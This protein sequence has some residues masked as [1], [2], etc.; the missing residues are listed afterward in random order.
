MKKIPIIFDCDTGTDDAIAI[1]S[2]L[3]SKEL[4]IRAFTTV[5]GNVHLR[6]T[7]RNT[8]N[9]VDYLGFKIKVAAGADKPLCRELKVAQCHGED[10]LGGIYL[11][12]AK[13]ELYEKDAIETIYEEALKLRGELEIVAVGPLT[14]IAQ[15]LLKHPDLKKLIKHITIMGGAMRGGNMTQVAEFNIFVDP[16]AAKIV[17]EAGIP[18]TM[19]GLDVT[20][21][22][23]IS[24]EEMQA[25]KTIDTKAGKLTYEI[26]NYMVERS[27][28]DNLEEAV[29]HDGLALGVCIH[30][31][32]VNTES[33]YVNVETKGEFTY[34]HTFCD[35]ENITGK[36][37]NCQVALQVDAEAYKAWLLN[38]ILQS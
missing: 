38:T 37:P 21:K 30:P 22:T 4:D 19:V 34:G 32:F 33:Y 16:E 12:K 11:P 15:A 9:L 7:A 1:I 23:I 10:G 13:A 36:E 24:E 20:L 29:M 14:N 26:L 3:Y 18:M 5:S 28:V 35:V 25:Y 31:E 2:A 27:K 17:F 6:H 8:L